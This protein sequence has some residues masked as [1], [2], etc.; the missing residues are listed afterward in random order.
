[1]LMH[2][3]FEPNCVFIKKN[4]TTINI[5]NYQEY[6]FLRPRFTKLAPIYINIRQTSRLVET[7]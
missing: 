2:K 7:E 5:H 4:S 6:N 1:M 3:K